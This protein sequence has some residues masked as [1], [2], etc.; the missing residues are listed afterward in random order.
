M[1]GVSRMVTEDGGIEN[2]GSIAK[3]IEALSQKD[4]CQVSTPVKRDVVLFFSFDVVNSTAYKTVNYYG[5]AKVLNALF[6]TLQES[7][8]KRIGAEMWRVLGDEAIFI[9]KVRDAEELQNTISKIYR[10]MVETIYNLKSG[11]FFQQDKN[12]KLMIHQNILSLKTA[13]WLAIVSNVGDITE[14]EIGLEEDDCIFERYLSPEG[15]EIFEFLGNDIDTGFRIASYV[16]DGRMVLSYELAYLVA[17]RTESLSFLHIITYKKLKGVWKD[18]LYPIIWYHEPKAYLDF[19]KREIHFEDSFLFD[20]YAEN[21]LIREYFDN[22][23]DPRPIRDGKMYT[24]PYYALNK[25]LQDRELT[26]KIERLREWIRETK[27]DH[28][29]YM[30]KQR[31]HCVAVCYAEDEED[32]EAKILIA[33]RKGTRDKLGGKWEFGCAKAVSSKTVAEVIQE[34]YREDFN[35]AIEPVLDESREMKE[36]VPFALYHVDQYNSTE[37]EPNMDTGVITLAK[38][39]E[40]YEVENFRPTGKHEKVRWVRESELPK[41]KE[42]LENN[43]VPDFERTLEQA[44]QMIRK[45]KGQ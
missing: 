40:T 5:W 31:L 27:R 25:I 6:K 17:Q 7:V 38:V 30:E 12:F 32:G 21:D 1:A 11:V 20:D 9:I 39:V 45:L 33:K 23:D 29:R 10:I 14:K 35:I 8:Q 15:N 28:T 34:E 19:Y 26:G 24:D 13:A 42:V 3:E 22:R 36:P 16:Q 4:A 37:A 18:R 43:M 44:F 41:I 2:L